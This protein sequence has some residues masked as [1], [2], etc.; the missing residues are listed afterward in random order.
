MRLSPRTCGSKN[1]RIACWIPCEI[2]P[3][4]SRK[5]TMLDAARRLEDQST[6]PGYRLDALSGNHGCHLEIIPA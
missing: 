2:W 3:I 4:V 5:L 6:L 1:S